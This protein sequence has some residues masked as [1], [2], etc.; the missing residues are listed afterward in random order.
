MSP[1]QARGRAVDK[2]TD[3]WS[4]GCVLYEMLAGTKPFAGE[5]TSDL[6]VAILEA[7]SDLSRCPRRRRRAVR[8][9]LQRCSKRMSAR[10][11]GYRRRKRTEIDDELSGKT[12][13][14]IAVS[15]TFPA[16]V[17]CPRRRRRCAPRRGSAIGWIAAS[18]S[19]EV[20]A[21]AFD[22]IV[23]IVATAA[24]EYSPVLSPSANGNRVPV[25]R[26][27]DQR[28]CG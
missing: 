14:G 6:I 28:T 7:Q 4:F 2:R 5:S 11:R 21:P 17:A 9:L 19:N 26:A 24:H 8:R 12:S 22:R 10:L 15:I 1:E 27:G 13:A 3:V 16:A 25:E 20:A 18:R 23:R